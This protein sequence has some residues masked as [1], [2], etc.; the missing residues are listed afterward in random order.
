MSLYHMLFGTEPAAGIALKMLGLIFSDVPRFRDAYFT[1]ADKTTMTDSVIVILTRT[2]GG[3][4]DFYENKYRRQTHYPEDVVGSAGPWNE[5]LRKLPG[6][7]HDRDHADDTTYANFYFDVPE[8][9]KQAV[10]D[11][12]KATGRPATLNE[13]FAA[14]IAALREGRDVT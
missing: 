13:K 14:A 11:Y 7:R 10:I 5:D 3:N 2:G 4:R 12:L 9:E 8:A 6:Y 1:W